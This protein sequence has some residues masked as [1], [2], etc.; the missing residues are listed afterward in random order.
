ML[1]ADRERKRQ[2]ERERHVIHD[3]VQKPLHEPTVG[4]VGSS[5]IGL[6]SAR[7]TKPAE[8]SPYHLKAEFLPVNPQCLGLGPYSNI[9]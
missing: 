8:V 5:F 6:Q 9:P 7:N 4:V 3:L 2:R 1:T